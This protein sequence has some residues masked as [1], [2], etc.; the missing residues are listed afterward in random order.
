MFDIFRFSHSCSESDIESI[1]LTGRDAG[2]LGVQIYFIIKYV[3]GVH[4]QRAS[5]L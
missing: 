4:G 1:F 2:T 3:C 5:A